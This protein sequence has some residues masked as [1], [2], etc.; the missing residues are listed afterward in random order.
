MFQP[1]VEKPFWF[2]T[3]IDKSVI[4][5]PFKK[6]KC[7]HR[8]KVMLCR[9]KNW[10]LSKSFSRSQIFGNI[11]HK[12]FFH[13]ERS[14]YMKHVL[15]ILIFHPLWAQIFPTVCN[16]CP[17]Q[18]RLLNRNCQIFK[19]LQLHNCNWGKNLEASL[20]SWQ[21]VRWQNFPFL[22]PKVMTA[23]FWKVN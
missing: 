22:A 1:S 9:K 8:W 10:I 7:L 11:K 16:G 12:R 21:L 5:L 3:S 18:E 2:W 20:E 13:C 14:N 15:D 6:F 17:T 4:F 19:S 23:S